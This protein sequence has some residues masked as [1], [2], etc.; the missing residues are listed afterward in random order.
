MK[1]QQNTRKFYQKKRLN[2]LEHSLSTHMTWWTIWIFCDFTMKWTAKKMI[3][4]GMGIYTYVEYIERH[5]WLKSIAIPID[6][7]KSPKTAN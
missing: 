6:I 7:L 4:L 3:E 2:Q 1:Q 5:E